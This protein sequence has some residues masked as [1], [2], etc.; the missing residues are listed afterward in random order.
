MNKIMWAWKLFVA[1]V[2]K[3]SKEVESFTLSSVPSPFGNSL[4]IVRFE[5][6]YPTDPKMD[7][8]SDDKDDTKR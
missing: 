2:S 7:D 1:F 5:V 3:S 6:D 4:K 8:E